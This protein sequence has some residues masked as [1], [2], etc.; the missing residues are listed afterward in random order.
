MNLSARRAIIC[1]SYCSFGK[2]EGTHATFG[3]CER[4]GIPFDELFSSY[5][6]K[7]FSVKLPLRTQFTSGA[8]K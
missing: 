1:F 4:L 6:R 8:N 5:R 2:D 3:Q 7:S